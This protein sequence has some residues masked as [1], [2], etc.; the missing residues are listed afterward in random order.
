MRIAQ[1]RAATPSA[2]ADP[3]AARLQTL[4]EEDEEPPSLP[5]GGPHA[6]PARRHAASS[7]RSS[8]LPPSPLR[9]APT[10]LDGSRFGA[11]LLERELLRLRSDF[12]RPAWMP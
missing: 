2:L 4:V 5:G 6:V 7:A 12:G 8:L 9:T 10:R 1:H 11:A 3:R